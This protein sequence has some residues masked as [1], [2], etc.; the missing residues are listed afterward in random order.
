MHQR[1]FLFAVFFAL[2]LCVWGL[3]CGPTAQ[4]IAK[5]KEEQRQK[6]IKMHKDAQDSYAKFVSD[7]KA[8]MPAWFRARYPQWQDGPEAH[9]EA[10]AWNAWYGAPVGSYIH[11][12]LL[13]T[14]LVGL[15]LYPLWLFLA[16]FWY[17]Q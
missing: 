3:G 2:F 5:E 1:H 11:P 12:L 13:T 6:L 16:C 14:S 4:E 9:P 15:V 8:L 17:S 10:D 7:E